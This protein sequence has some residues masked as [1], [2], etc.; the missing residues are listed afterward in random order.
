MLVLLEGP[1]EKRAAQSALKRALQTQWTKRE[2]RIV[3]WRPNSK[4]LTIVHNERYWYAGIVINDHQKGIKHWNSFGDYQA[5]GHLRIAVELNIAIED[6]TKRV[7]GFFAKDS[8]SGKVF[9]MHSGKIGG[10]A[11]GVGKDAFITWSADRLVVVEGTGGSSREG[12]L[13]A[14]VDETDTAPAIARFL[15]KVTRFKEAVA[16]KGLDTPD[17][18]QSM[19]DRDEYNR[20]FSGTKRGQRAEE[21]EYLSRHGD[22]VQAL[23]EMRLSKKA[24]DE[25]VPNSPLMDLYVKKNGL[26]TEVYEVKTSVGRQ[27][28]YGGIGQLC[29]H[30]P[31]SEAKKF[32][33]VPNEGRI[34]TDIRQALSRLNIQLL[35]FTLTQDSVQLH[36]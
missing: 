20:E 1:K 29:V 12:F 34:A 27:S 3:T 31:S 17:F 26:I 13:V 14:A 35:R 21:F 16:E 19:H 4:E 24:K 10:G 6:P 25:L 9:V 30:C 2:R 18:K 8:V 7:A 23:R 5:K 22:V 11:P 33:V 28:L 15:N 32:L 36:A